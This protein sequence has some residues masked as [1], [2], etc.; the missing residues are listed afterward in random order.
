MPMVVTDAT[1]RD[2]PIVMAN[3]AFLNLTGY[4]SE[5]VL[6]RNCRFLQG[7]GTSAAA[8][9]EVRAALEESREVSVELLNY[10]KDGS[11]F[12]NQL[13]FSPIFDDDGRLAYHFGSQIDRTDYRRVQSLEAAE[14][15]LLLEVDHRAN[16]VL[17]LVDSIVRLSRAED[18]ALYAA[19]IQ[20]RV[21]ALAR[22]HSLLSQRGWH[23]IP[24]SETISTQIEPY[25]AR[26]AIMDGPELLLVAH[27]VQPL[28]LFVHELAVN[29]ATHGSL[30]REAG[31][32][33]I[34]WEAQPTRKG[35]SLSWKEI[36]GPPPPRARRRGFGT[37][38]ADATIRQQL[39]GTAEREWAD[40]GVKVT[41]EV[42]N[43]TN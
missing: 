19:S 42:P 13:H 41:V 39:H 23:D 11:T 29:A 14:H 17:A 9:A 30:S 32:V 6:G 24:L 31:R 22:A 8:V 43:V 18:A 3:Q 37:V 2:Y 36:G 35:L 20:N 21:Q 5:E 28:A 1:Q 34:T 40:Q 25:A 33:E 27:A 26:R 4:A 16:N 10:R 38:I 15:R 12:W 7:P